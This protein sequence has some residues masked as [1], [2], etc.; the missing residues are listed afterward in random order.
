M[1]HKYII[2]ECDGGKIP[3]VFHEILVHK[4]VAGSIMSQ[5]RNIF[6]NSKVISAGFYDIALN[7][8][9]GES[10]SL[11]LKAD[12]NDAQIISGTLGDSNA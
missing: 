10:V 5:L 7:K 8:C 9:Y 11:K 2:F 4:L 1:K 3:V 6:D 12:P